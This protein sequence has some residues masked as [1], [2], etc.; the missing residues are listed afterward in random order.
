MRRITWNLPRVWSLTILH[1]RYIH[2]LKCFATRYVLL[3][4]ENEVCE[5][6]VFTRVCL[7]YASYWNGFLFLFANRLTIMWLTEINLLSL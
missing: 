6:Y 3:P 5:G 2:V 7:R 1:Y 4:P